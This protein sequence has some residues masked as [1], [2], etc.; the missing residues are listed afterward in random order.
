LQVI[1][2]PVDLFLLRDSGSDKPA[3]WYVKCAH[4]LSDGRY[5]QDLRIETQ[6]SKNL[7]Q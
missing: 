1:G 3:A 2:W 4:R 7:F 6:I 5:P